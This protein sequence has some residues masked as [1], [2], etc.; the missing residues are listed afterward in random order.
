MTIYYYYYYFQV[1]THSA[2]FDFW[3]AT[4]HAL[5]ATPHGEKPTSVEDYERQTG[6]EAKDRQ[7]EIWKQQGITVDHHVK[8]KSGKA[9]GYND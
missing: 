2:T 7:L 3:P 8:S 4:R 9:R 5:R 6:K 1:V